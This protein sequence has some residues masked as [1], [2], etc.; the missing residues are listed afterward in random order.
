MAKPIVFLSST[1]Y[2]LRYIRNDLERFVQEMGYDPI[3]NE[4]G[5]IAYGRNES[6]EQ[7]CYREISTC[8]IL[9]HIVG[10]KYGSISL[11][12]P[13]SISQM[14]LKTAHDLHKQIYVFVESPVHV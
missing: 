1:F 7:Y 4:R 11:K 10:G 14:E 5:Q 3:M 9:V 6:L 2:D 13:Y 12:E 8:D